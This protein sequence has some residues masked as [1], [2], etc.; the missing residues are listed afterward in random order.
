[1]HIIIYLFLFIYVPLAWMQARTPPKTFFWS[2]TWSIQSGLDPFRSNYDR[3]RNRGANQIAR[4]DFIQWWTD[5]LQLRN[6]HFIKE[7]LVWTGFPQ[8]WL[9]LENSDV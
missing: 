3:F 9:Q 5:D 8:R 6:H 4:V 2:G 1:M 7:R